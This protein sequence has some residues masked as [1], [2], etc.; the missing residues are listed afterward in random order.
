MKRE[1][2]WWIQAEALPALYQLYELAEDPRYFVRL[3]KT[4][5]FIERYQA[6]AEF[7]GW[8]WGITEDGKVG[9]RGDG[10]GEE[11]KAAYHDLRALV[12]TSE[13]IG[14]RPR[15]TVVLH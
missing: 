14:S 3:Q 5:D 4:L 7:G 8:Y 10:K 13:W 1:K 12:F 9:P 11:W 6:D 15:R 2:I